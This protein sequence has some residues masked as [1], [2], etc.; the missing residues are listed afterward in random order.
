MWMARCKKLL[1]SADKQAEYHNPE[2]MCR[3]VVAMGIPDKDIV[4][5][6]AGQRIYDI[7]DRIFRYGISTSS[8]PQNRHSLTGMGINLSFLGMLEPIS[9][10]YPQI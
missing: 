2:V 3:S 6:H 5:D 1:M 10:H 9:L 4:P 8:S 7:Y